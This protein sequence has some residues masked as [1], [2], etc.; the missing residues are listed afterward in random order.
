ME[1]LGW[2]IEL[3]PRE[4][5]PMSSAE[6]LVASEWSMRGYLISIQVPDGM[7]GQDPRVEKLVTLIREGF[8][9]IPM[10]EKLPA[11]YV[12]PASAKAGMTEAERMTLLRAKVIK[13]WENRQCDLVWVASGS[14]D[15]T[16]IEVEIPPVPR[17]MQPL[18]PFLVYPW[19][20]S[21]VEFA[22]G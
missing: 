16:V 20:I 18:V 2:T 17:D 8:G 21:L 7:N 9:H 15:C 6:K 1:I 14:S 13:Q 22:F 4:G 12:E 11:R 5:K 19:I 10:P 3:V